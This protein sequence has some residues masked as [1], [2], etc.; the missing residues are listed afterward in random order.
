MDKISKDIFDNNIKKIEFLYALFDSSYD[1]NDLSELDFYSDNFIFNSIDFSSDN[2]TQS[3]LIEFVNMDKNK[4]LEIIF[5]NDMLT[6]DDSY[7]DIIDKMQ[8]G[9][10]SLGT[11]IKVIIGDIK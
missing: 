3:E 9:E 8:N 1:I 10:L 2:Y 5:S 4:M 7:D 6:F 11:K